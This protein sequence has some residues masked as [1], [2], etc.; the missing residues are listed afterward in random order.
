MKV[1][2]LRHR[3]GNR[4][5]LTIHDHKRTPPRAFHSFK[6]D[7]PEEAMIHANT[8]RNAYFKLFRNGKVGGWDPWTD[9]KNDIDH[10]VH[11]YLTS[12]TSLSPNTIENRKTCLRVF[13]KHAQVESLAL[14]DHEMIASFIATLKAASTKNK[15]T[16][17]L[18]N[19]WKWSLL[20]G[21]ARENPV[22]EYLMRRTSKPKEKQRRSE[23]S[24]EQYIK[25]YGAAKELK[26]M[27]DY[28]PDYLEII[29]STGLRRSELLAINVQDVKT[30]GLTG[31]VRIW[32]WT[33]PHTGEWFVPKNERSRRV[34]P[35][36]PRAA[37]ILKQRLDMVKSDDPWAKVFPPTA[38]EKAKGNH[39]IDV[40]NP[41]KAFLKA[42]RK[43]GLDDS[44]VLHSTRHSA[45]SWLIM[46]GVD[47]YALMKIAGHA[48]LQTQARY[49]HFCEDMLSGG[50]TRVRRE[51]INFLC[52]GISDEVINFVFPESNAWYK[53]ID[54]ESKLD[55]RNVL[56]GGVLYDKELIENIKRESIRSRLQ[57]N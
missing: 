19:F 12:N 48:N 13:L 25:V 34:V 45:L 51:I 6:A 49:I 14:V 7:S 3:G 57:Q 37:A 32:K 28:F 46:A 30:D 43:V 42:R 20:N 40:G 50:A 38:K 54:S 44:Y 24:V 53:S 5:Q 4:Y 16:G 18:K 36:T 11:E 15:W 56:Y 27:S 31:S 10:A 47:P 2:G 52:P 39:R 9:T 8:M 17:I 55:I 35:L 21:Y 22:E 29:V 23:M 41:T 1:P 33:N 26:M